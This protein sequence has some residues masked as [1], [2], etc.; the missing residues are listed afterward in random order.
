M[1][2]ADQVAAELPRDPRRPCARPAAAETLRRP[3]FLPPPTDKGDTA[4][5]FAAFVLLLAVVSAPL[6]STALPPLVDYPNHLTR[7]QLI[8]TDGDEFY[9]VRWAPLPDLAAD[10]VV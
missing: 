10:L 8:A 1:V 6:F 5:I 2:C 4:K 9:A 3:R 7:L